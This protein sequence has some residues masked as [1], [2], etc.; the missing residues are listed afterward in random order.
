MSSD[1]YT[2][3]QRNVRGTDS[4]TLLRMHDLAKT[5]LTTSAS[6]QERGRAE[7]AVQRIAREL[8]RRDVRC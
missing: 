3:E 1:A 2:F 6:V 4:N 8:Q 7:R 5:V